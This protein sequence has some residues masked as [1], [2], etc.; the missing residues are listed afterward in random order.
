MNKYEKN[1]IIKYNNIASDYDTSADGRFTAKFKNK[2]LE[3]CVI[4]DGSRVLDVGCGN[5]SLI[6]GIKQK[7]DIE[8]YGI[9]ISPEMIKECRKRYDNIDFRVSGGEDIPFEDNNF[10]IVIICCAL[11]HLNNPEKFFQEAKR[12]LK[13]DGILIV[14]EPCFPF[15]I[16]KIADWIVSPLI[17]AGDNKLFSNKKLK[18]LFIKNA[19]HIVETYKKD[20]IQIVIGKSE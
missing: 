5:G 13:T 14:G 20:V 10:D 3:L 15:L 16:R 11:H 7:N 8:A 18:N 19:F 9:D 6:S 12:L 2:I 17:K 1:S 4:P